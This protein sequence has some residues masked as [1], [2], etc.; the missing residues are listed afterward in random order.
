MEQSAL[1]A[2]T[3]AEP[4]AP[5]SLPEREPR[6]PGQDV[7]R[8]RAQPRALRGTLA[9]EGMT[10][11]VGDDGDVAREVLDV[12]VRS[13][14]ATERAQVG[15]QPQ[16]DTRVNILEV[17]LAGPPQVPP[18]DLPGQRPRPPLQQLAQVKAGGIVV[19]RLQEGQEDPVRAVRFR[20]LRRR[21]V[22]RG[23]HVADR[24]LLSSSAQ[25]A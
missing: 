13:G 3:A 15:R 20:R 1:S 9:Q 23:A 12:R 8:P 2:R 11:I 19:R 24:P 17:A 18:D 14:P 10:R 7:A 21:E 4:L 5:L 6:V 22:R 16:E 25:R